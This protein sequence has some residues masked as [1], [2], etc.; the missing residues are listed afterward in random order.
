MSK[1]TLIRSRCRKEGE[2]RAVIWEIKKTFA[3]L[4][5]NDRQFQLATE[6]FYIEQLI[7]ER[8]ALFSHTSTLLLL[9]RGKREPER[10]G[11]GKACPQ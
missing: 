9:L 3:S 7:F 5:E 4:R 10:S 11:E 8:A 1:R 2:M 6:A